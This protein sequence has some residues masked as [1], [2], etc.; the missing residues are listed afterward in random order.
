MTTPTYA[1]SKPAPLGIH[2]GRNGAIPCTASLSKILM[3]RTTPTGIPRRIGG[4]PSLFGIAKLGVGSLNQVQCQA[5]RYGWGLTTGYGGMQSA[6]ASIST[7]SIST[8]P[9]SY[10]GAGRYVSSGTDDRLAAKAS[11]VRCESFKPQASMDTDLGASQPA[12]VRWG[13]EGAMVK[14]EE[15]KYY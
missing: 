5:L 1:F 7:M 4:T 8:V 9:S 2:Q 10:G 11:R 3:S 6:S 12:G 14:E 15:N 13:F